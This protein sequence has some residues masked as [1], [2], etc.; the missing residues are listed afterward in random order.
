V[1]AAIEELQ[2]H[3]TVSYNDNLSLLTIRGTTPEI[4]E[5]AKTGRTIMLSQSTR[6][7]ARLVVAEKNN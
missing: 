5:Q 7:T 4:L 3:F 6:R 1:P 2:K